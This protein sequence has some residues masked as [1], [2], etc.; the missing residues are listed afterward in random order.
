MGQMRPRHRVTHGGERLRE[1]FWLL[2]K[3]LAG[4]TNSSLMWAEQ[5]PPELTEQRSIPLLFDSAFIF[6]AKTLLLDSL[7]LLKTVAYR[8]FS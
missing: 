8:C 6:R 2:G 1:G 5:H 7:H 4:L 3:D